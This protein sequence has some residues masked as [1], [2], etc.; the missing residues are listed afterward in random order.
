MDI[1]DHDFYAPE[2]PTVPADPVGDYNDRGSAFSGSQAPPQQQNQQQQQQHDDGDLEEGEEED[3]GADMDEDDSDIDIITERK[4]GSKPPPPTQSRY[5]DIRNIPQRSASTDVATKSAVKKEDAPAKGTSGAD[6]AA[7]STS[8]VDVNAIPI[9]KPAGKPI[10]QVNIDEDLPEN[11]KPWRKPGT[12][13]SDYFNYG[14]DEFTWALY[15]AKQ[16]SVRGEYSQDTISQ[17]SRKM[18]EEMQM[19]MMGGMPGAGGSMAPT[20]PGMD[21]MPPEMQAMMQHMMA[22]GLDPSQM[23]ASALTAMFSGM[24]SAG[25]AGAAGVQ[26]QSFGGSGQGFSGAQAQNF[27]YDQGMARGGGGGGGGFGSGGGSGGGGG[28]GGGSRGR[29]GRRNW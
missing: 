21:G 15:A 23:D 27:G 3:E 11:D 4:D 12:D 22:S 9:Y 8:T 10:T 28:G 6:L 13:L 16:E 2:E 24:Q 26:G 14:F 25:G 29:G 17:N 7:V 20:L 18:M 1:D 19:M 5:S